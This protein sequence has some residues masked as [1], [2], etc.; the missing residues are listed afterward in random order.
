[1]VDCLYCFWAGLVWAMSEHLFCIHFSASAFNFNWGLFLWFVTDWVK[2]SWVYVRIGIEVKNWLQIYLGWT[3]KFR[4][5]PSPRLK[6][7][8]VSNN[9][10]IG[11]GELGQGVRFW[12]LRYKLCSKLGFNKLMSSHGLGLSEGW[13]DFFSGV[14]GWVFFFFFFENEVRKFYWKSK[15]L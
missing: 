7:W 1:M 14:R 8:W 9:F 12:L 3:C 4:P 2:E 11:L 10:R 13:W 6:I 5:G 15:P